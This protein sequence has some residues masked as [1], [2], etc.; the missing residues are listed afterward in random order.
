M[1]QRLRQEKLKVISGDSINPACYRLVLTGGAIA[2]A[3]CPGQF[4][5][6]KV[7]DGTAPLLR[8]PLGI[9]SVKNGRLSVLYEVVGEG[10]RALSA[11]KPGEY[12]DVIGPLGNG[13]DPDVR[14]DTPCVILVAG[15][16]GVAPLVFLAEKLA[17]DAR[18]KIYVFMGARTKNHILCKKEFKNLGCEVKVATDDG[19]CGFRGLVT[20]LLSDYLRT[21]PA[22]RRGR[23][24]GLPTMYACG[25]PAMLAGV[26]SLSAR[27]HLCAYGSFEAHMACGIGACMGCVIKIRDHSSGEP[28]G[29]VY[30]R[31]CK[32][33]PVFPL[34]QVVF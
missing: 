30:K 28:S 23:D 4:V 18:R 6:V 1:S 10:T 21:T 5:M 3:A 2:P 26:A 12:L 27:H 32:D 8:R 22:C 19:S 31:V 25:P 33:G 20:A 9:H 24:F 17:A 29:F 34:N 13:F 7:T 16:I 14:R 11:C 15:G